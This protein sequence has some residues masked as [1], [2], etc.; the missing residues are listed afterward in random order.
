MKGPSNGSE[1]FSL[2]VRKTWVMPSE[3]VATTADEAKPF[4]VAISR[5][6]N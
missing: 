6:A 2:N 4:C 5:A 1:V 3:L